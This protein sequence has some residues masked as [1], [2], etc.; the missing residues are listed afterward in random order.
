MEPEINPVIATSSAFPLN[1][2]P[3]LSFLSS[4]SFSQVLVAIVS[5]SLVTLLLTRY[6]EAMTEKRKLFADAY[7][8]ALAWQEM[9][10]RVRRRAA[11]ISE[12]RKLVE[13]FHQLQ[14]EIDYY[15]GLVSTESEALGLSYE[16]F[17]NRVKSENN[18]LIQE[19]WESPIQRPK[20]GILKSE[21]HPNTLAV[22][23]SFLKDTRDWLSIWQVP[24]LFVHWRNWRQK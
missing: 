10:Y 14:E 13:R 11:G 6:F 9:L 7:K 15:Q 8:T 17:V 23:K 24:K 3:M 12:E 19:A 4:S 1:L 2:D 5:S 22:G 21:K 20:S 18:R 16:R